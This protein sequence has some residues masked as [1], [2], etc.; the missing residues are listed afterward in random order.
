MVTDQLCRMPLRRT[1]THPERW[2][3][4][5]PTGF[6]FVGD[7][8]CSDWLSARLSPK[9]ALAVRL[10]G[11]RM[12]RMT[13]LTSNADGRRLTVSVTEAAAAWHWT[14]TR[15]RS[16]SK[17]RAPNDPRRSSSARPGGCDRAVARRYHEDNSYSVVSRLAMASA[18]SCWRCSSACWYVS[19][20]TWI[21]AWPSRSDTTFSGTPASNANVAC[22]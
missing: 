18:A 15:L 3:L 6:A 5:G 7:R 21:D 12:D 17:G 20:V 14:N 1:E 10:E 8:Q 2:A 22:V 11:L 19:A 16:R 9:F 4:I 13:A